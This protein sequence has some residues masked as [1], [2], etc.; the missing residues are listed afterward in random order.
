MHILY[1]YSYVALLFLQFKSISFYVLDN[2]DAGIRADVGIGDIIVILAVLLVMFSMFCVMFICCV[3]YISTL[4]KSPPNETTVQVP[5]IQVHMHAAIS[6]YM[7]SYI[8]YVAKY[9]LVTNSTALFTC[10]YTCNGIQCV[11]VNTNI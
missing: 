4:R 1:N 9:N 5:Q 6:C 11:L 8:N 7:A 10:I 3:V 2:Q